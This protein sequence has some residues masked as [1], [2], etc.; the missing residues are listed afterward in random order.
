MNLDAGNLV[1]GDADLISLPSNPINGDVGSLPSANYFLLHPS[2]SPLMTDPQPAPSQPN[3]STLNSPNPPKPSSSNPPN[4]P[5]PNPPTLNPDPPLSTI[6]AEPPFLISPIHP[7]L[8][9]DS[10]LPTSHPDSLN[11]KPLTLPPIPNPHPTRLVKNR[12]TKPKP[13]SV[14]PQP[15][16]TGRK[17]GR[18]PPP[19]TLNQRVRGSNEEEGGE[20]LGKEG[21]SNKEEGGEFLELQC[22]TGDFNSIRLAEERKGSKNHGRIKEMHDFNFF[23][24]NM[25]LLDLLD[26]WVKGD[27]AWYCCSSGKCY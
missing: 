1:N 4:S 11:Q 10:D 17:P 14:R 21:G 2:H 7:N 3:T 23:I 20:F 9:Q 12:S 18:P 13:K 6:P 19:V 25:D 8:N 15:P 22:L 27:G 26:L 5:R 24:N 16:K